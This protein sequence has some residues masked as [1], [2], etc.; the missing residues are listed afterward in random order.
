M[1]VR[2]TDKPIDYHLVTESVRTPR[3]GAVVLFLGTVR[4]FT[5]DQ[6][7]TA[8]DYDAYPEMAIT[9]MEELV[10]EAGEKWPIL[11]AVI[12]H[13]VGHLELGEV[14]VAVAV[15]SPHRKEAFHAGQFLIDELKVRVPIWKKENWIDGQSEWVHPGEEESV[16]SNT[17]SS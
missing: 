7:T 8:L 1:T 16:R 14:C 17:P 9:K 11:N 6:Q 10:A 15:S 12:E 13:R 3:A 2:L 5:D 4:E